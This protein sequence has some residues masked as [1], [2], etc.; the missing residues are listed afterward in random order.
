MISVHCIQCCLWLR[1]DTH[2][3]GQTFSMTEICRLSWK[4]DFAKLFPTNTHIYSNLCQY[5]MPTFYSQTGKLEN[6]IVLHY[7]LH[8][9]EIETTNVALNRAIY[10]TVSS[11]SLRLSRLHQKYGGG[12]FC[13][14]WH[15]AWATPLNQDKYCLFS[16]SSALTGPVPF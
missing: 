14:P 7:R 4:S 1:Q 9:D 13:F 5:S 3:I 8:W 15:V 6:G 2:I 16:S 11:K 10:F 12:H